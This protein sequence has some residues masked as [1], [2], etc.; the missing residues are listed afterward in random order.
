V[1]LISGAC[2]A[3]V[4]DPAIANEFSA[5]SPQFPRLFT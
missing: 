1:H 2:E 5:L 3:E 4:A